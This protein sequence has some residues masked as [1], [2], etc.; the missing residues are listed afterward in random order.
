VDGDQVAI[1]APAAGTLTGWV[2]PGNPG[3][4]DQ[5]VGRIQILGTGPLQTIK[6]PGH[7]TVAVNDAVEG[8]Y[9]RPAPNWPTAYNFNDIYV[10]AR[11]DETERQ[12]RTSRCTR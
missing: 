11:V 2:I 8:Q 1:N 10:T 4:T 12:G 3:T 9:V 6:F 7:G 5:V